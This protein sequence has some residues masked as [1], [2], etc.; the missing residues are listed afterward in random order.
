LREDE[1]YPLIQVFNDL[2]LSKYEYVSVHAPSERVKYKEPELVNILKVFAEKTWPII[3]HP[4]IIENFSLWESLG[5]KLCI[6]NMDKRK[7]CGRTVSDLI[8][9]FNELPDAGFC[10]DVA[11]AKQVDPTMT[12]CYLMIKEFK[13]KLVQLHLS[14]VTSESKHVRLN[15]Q[16]ITAYQKI[17]KYLPD[18][19]PIILES[20]ILNGDDQKQ[21][22]ANEI[23]LAAELFQ[24]SPTMSY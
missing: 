21:K 19:L 1:L 23:M 9:I 5:S 20:P 11:H 18:S 3:V 22:I 15:E 4:D 24:Q 16:A 2:D 17:L 14:D 8:R 10:L 13:E 12:E 7:P 6:E